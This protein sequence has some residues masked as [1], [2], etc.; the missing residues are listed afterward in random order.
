MTGNAIVEKLR[1]ALSDAVDSECK[2][3]YILAESRK[4]LETCPPD[5][6][7]FAL[8]LY[9]HWALHV[10]LDKP[11]TTLPFLKRVDKYAA[12]FLAGKEDIAEGHR[13]LTEFVSLDTF[14][15]QFAQLLKAY[16]LPTG[17]CDEK[18]RWYEFL[19]HYASVIEDGS[20]SLS[21]K[22]KT[23]PL[24]QIKQVVF[25]KGRVAAPE[26]NFYIPF[27]LVWTIVLLNGKELKVE[28]KAS[29]PNGDETI[30]AVTT[31]H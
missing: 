12:S 23:N 14:R 6:V 21:P 29:G 10:D 25:T 2:V 9:C 17:I 31:L 27:G 15:Q 18:P 22:A 11:G 8:K 4:L 13:M 1:V 19:K 26:E 30:S 3:V 5:P 28:V 24:K 7:P 20:L 16:Q